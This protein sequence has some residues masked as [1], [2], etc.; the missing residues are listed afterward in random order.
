MD[1]T[2]LTDASAPVPTPPA[3]IYAQP[4]PGVQPVYV[5]AQ[6]QQPAVVTVQ[7]VAIQQ[8]Q[9]PTMHAQPQMAQPQT[10]MY[11]QPQQPI[12]Y[13][14]PQM[15]QQ[16]MVSVNVNVNGGQLQLQGMGGLFE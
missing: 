15:V 11:A 16:Q 3:L 4:A 2:S 7:P 1:K 8:P 10:V 14:Q 12:M 6:Q 5:Q 9:Q 13:V